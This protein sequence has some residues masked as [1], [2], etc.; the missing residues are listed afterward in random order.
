MEETSFKQE[1]DWFYE[2]QGQRKG[3]LPESRIIP[4]IKASNIKRNTLVWKKGFNDWKKV[5]DTELNAHLH[6]IVSTNTD[7]PPPLAREHV[8]N[9]IVWILAFAPILG[10]FLEY[11]VAGAYY[12]DVEAAQD[13]VLDNKFWFVT[14]ILNIGLSYLDAQRLKSAGY[15]TEKIKGWVWLVPVYLYQRAKH[16]HHSLVHFIV[17]LVS[18]ATILFV[19]SNQ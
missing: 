8:S 11:F 9:R 3:P 19:V 2:E 12:E 7:L 18:F 17:W 13:A 15:D 5:E 4:L 14:L 16:M 10:Y 1:S 6:R